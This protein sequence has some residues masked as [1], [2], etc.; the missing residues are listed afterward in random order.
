[1]TVG[2]RSGKDRTLA[3]WSRYRARMN[4]KSP[5]AVL[6]SVTVALVL[7]ACGGS[8]AK[9]QLLDQLRQEA[10]DSGAPAEV[11]DCVIEAM[12]G[13]S[14][15]ELTSVL[16][17]TSTEATQEKVASAMMDCGA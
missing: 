1:M 15:A 13:L 4:L 7:S 10:T 6:V 9:A 11:V 8:D 14:E 17:D 3:A 12:G 16:E 2:R 5:A